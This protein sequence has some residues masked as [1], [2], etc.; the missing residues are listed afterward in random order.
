MIPGGCPPHFPTYQSLDVHDGL[1]S[2]ASD[3]I[4]RVGWAH[5]DLLHDE[6]VVAL[7]IH[8]VETEKNGKKKLE[9]AP[10]F[11]GLIF[12]THVFEM[13]LKSWC[14]SWLTPAL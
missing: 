12:P 7:P 3:V 9:W 11:P 1:L 14:P 5:G 2:D 4:L 10:I 6:N 8:L 13:N